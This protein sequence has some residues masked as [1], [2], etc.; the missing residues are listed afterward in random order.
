MGEVWVLASYQE[1]IKMRKA[2]RAGK[3][4]RIGTHKK[5]LHRPGPTIDRAMFF[6]KG[7]LEEATP[8]KRNRRGEEV[9]KAEGKGRGCRT[10]DSKNSADGKAVTKGKADRGIEGVTCRKGL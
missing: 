1:A 7:G 5:W 10:I 8:R 9:G 3:R 4:A 2:K 6:M